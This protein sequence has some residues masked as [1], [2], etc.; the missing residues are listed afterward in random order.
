MTPL[1]WFLLGVGATVLAVVGA[2]LWFAWSI[3]RMPM[4]PPRAAEP[5]RVTR[6]AAIEVIDRSHEE[7]RRGPWVS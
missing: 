5:R 3:E 4:E 1:L 2:A 7:H 6:A